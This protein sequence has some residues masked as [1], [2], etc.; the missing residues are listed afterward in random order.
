MRKKVVFPLS[1]SA[2][3]QPINLLVFA[4]VVIANDV[5]NAKNVVTFQW[6]P[7]KLHL[8]PHPSANVLHLLETLCHVPF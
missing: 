8:C 2:I 3:L 1:S 5:V 6:F 4:I 7:S